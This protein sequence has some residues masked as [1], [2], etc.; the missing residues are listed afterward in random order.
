MLKKLF[1]YSL[2]RKPLEALVFYIFYFI[3]IVIFGAIV[4][5]V[6]GLATGQQNDFNFGVKVG[7]YLAILN[8][9]L[10]TLAVLKSK[11]MFSDLP[12]LALLPIVGVLSYFGGAFLG[13]IPATYLT[14][15]KIKD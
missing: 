12:Y 3:L 7:S 15:R 1:N 4:A 6:L 9:I 5:Y 13:L 2:E 14:T 11:K 10:L 8:S